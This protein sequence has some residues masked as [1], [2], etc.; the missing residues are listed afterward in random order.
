M[1]AM[2]AAPDR[3]FADGEIRLRPASPDDRAAAGAWL[4]VGAARRGESLWFAVADGEDARDLGLLVLLRRDGGRVAD[5]G[6]APADGAPPG[7]VL[8]AA[9]RLVARHAFAA[10]D[11]DRLETRL[12]APD[13]PAAAALASAGFTWVGVDRHERLV[14]SLVPRDLR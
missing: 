3:G 13:R 4:L 5:V 9:L 14:W 11:L 8:A 7:D 1:T 12:R 2:T 6:Y 10:L